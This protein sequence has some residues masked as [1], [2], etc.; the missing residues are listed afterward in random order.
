MDKIDRSELKSKAKEQLKGRWGLAIF[1]VFVS[2]VLVNSSNV[3][4][5]LNEE[6]NISQNLVLSFNLFGL[7]FSGV[8]FIGL[9]KFLLNFT[10]NKEEPK[11]SDL[12]SQFKIYF[13]SLGLYILILLASVVGLLLLL[14]PGIIVAL[15]FSQ[16]YYILAENPNKGI[17]ECLKESIELMK[18]HKWEFFVLELSFIGWWLLAILTLGIGTLWVSPYQ[19]VTETNFYLKLKHNL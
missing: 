8:L 18:G 6:F 9:C 17:I 5:M 12:F 19:K 15:M 1:T 14:I 13:K 3:I 10:T 16:A 7:L 11:F 2:N 4:D